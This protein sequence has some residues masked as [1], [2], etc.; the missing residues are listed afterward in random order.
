MPPA[1]NQSYDERYK[2]GYGSYAG[3]QRYTD[4]AKYSHPA[5]EMDGTTPN[6]ELDAGFVNNTTQQQRYELATSPK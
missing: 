3:G 4:A 1:Y 5:Q 2:D 6:S